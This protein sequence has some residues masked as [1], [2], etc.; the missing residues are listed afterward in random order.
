MLMF[1]LFGWIV[2]GFLFIPIVASSVFTVGL[3]LALWLDDKAE[4]KSE[5]K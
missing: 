2:P 3:V 4:K 5:G 1:D